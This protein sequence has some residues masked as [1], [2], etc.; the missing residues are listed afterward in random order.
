MTPSPGSAAFQRTVWRRRP[1]LYRGYVPAAMLRP[2]GRSRFNRWCAKG[3]RVR[4]YARTE[5]RMPGSATARALESALEGLAIYDH[6][7]E[8]GEP[9]TL[10]LNGVETVDRRLRRLQDSFAIPYWWRR[11]D[12]VATLSSPNGGIGFHAGREDGFIVQLR[13]TREWRV[14]GPRVLAASYVRSLCGHPAEPIAPMRR[15]RTKPLLSCRL[16]PGDALYIPA[17]FAHEGVTGVESLSLSVSWQGLSAFDVLTAL[18]PPEALDVPLRLAERA[19]LFRL[20]RDPP[21]PP[22][23]RKFMRSEIRASLRAVQAPYA[24]TPSCIDDF[25]DLLLS[26]K[27]HAIMESRNSSPANSA[28]RGTLG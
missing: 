17:L 19:E 18:Q 20:L 23:A 22:K 21:S 9:V 2:L 6:F 8:R 14:W 25:V 26:R 11:G 5:A 10:L 28:L 27:A 3:A 24:P 13:G 12:I 15:P 1:A 7:R 4:L 16:E